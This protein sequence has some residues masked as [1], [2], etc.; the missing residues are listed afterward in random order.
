MEWRFCFERGKMKN[1]KIQKWFTFSFFG[2]QLL[3]PIFR[4][5]LFPTDQLTGVFRG[6]V[7]GMAALAWP[8]RSD[9]LVEHLKAA[10][11]KNPDNAAAKLN[12]EEIE[13]LSDLLAIKP[14]KL[15]DRLRHICGMKEGSATKMEAYLEQYR[16]GGGGGGSEG[17]LP[18]AVVIATR[19]SISNE[20]G[21]G[22]ANSG[23]AATEATTIHVGSANSGAPTQIELEK[24]KE[25]CEE[26][27]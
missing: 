19:C 6:T 7:R 23:T 2:L 10:G 5:L 26:E 8:L 4:K 14:D 27:I 1:R 13:T 3:D 17:H 22:G 11:A 15:V 18:A 24:L 12:E 9:L 20:E 25:R 21:G 16:S